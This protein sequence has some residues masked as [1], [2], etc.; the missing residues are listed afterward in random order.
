[1][2]AETEKKLDQFVKNEVYANVSAFA[3][4]CL[5]QEPGAKSDIPLT[6]DDFENLETHPEYRGKYADFDGG[7]SEALRA[8]V[9]RLEELLT[10]ADDKTADAITDEIHEVE[11]LEPEAQEIFEY[12]L[13]S[14]ALAEDLKEQGE[15]VAESQNGPV[16]GRTETGQALSQDAHIQAIYQN[17]KNR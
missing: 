12:W 9:D 1:M 4:Y 8:E 10:D 5:Q 6:W 14:S 7:T 11:L 2:E 16:W 15:P 13:I 17:L 3:T